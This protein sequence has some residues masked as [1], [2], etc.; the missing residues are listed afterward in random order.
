[1]KKQNSYDILME[2]LTTEFSNIPNFGLT[3]TNE[4]VRKLFNITSY[5]MAEIVS[6]KN[7]VCSNFVPSV[8][9]AIFDSKK[10]YRESKYKH[11][12]N[13]DEVDFSETLHETIRLSYVGLFHKIEN[14]VNDVIVMTNALMK[15]GDEEKQETDIMK[16]TKEHFGFRIKDWNDNIFFYKINWISNCVKHYDGFPTKKP[17]PLICEHFKESERMKIGVDEFKKDCDDLIKFYPDMIRIMFYF[18]QYKIVTD[19]YA[20]LGDEKTSD[21]VEKFGKSVSML[22][23]SIEGMVDSLKPNI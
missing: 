3:Q 5:R 16:W 23:I 12:I 14:F 7:L 21:L 22:R 11:L 2:K 1:M 17:K 20:D 19:M 10:E 15:I 8:N 13:I 4:D 9:K 6:Y 18:T